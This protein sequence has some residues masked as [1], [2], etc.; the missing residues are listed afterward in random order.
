[1]KLR[2]QTAIE[3]ASQDTN[4]ANNL[5]RYSRQRVAPQCKVVKAR[6]GKG[7]SSNSSASRK[8]RQRF[9]QIGD[10][11]IDRYRP[12]SQSQEKCCSKTKL[13]SGGLPR[14]P[15]NGRSARHS[16]SKQGKSSP[17]SVGRHDPFQRLNDDVIF[18]VVSMLRPVDT[19]TLRRVSKLWKATSEFH[20]GQKLLHQH[21]PATIL[22]THNVCTR[23]EANLQYRRAR[24][25]E[26]LELHP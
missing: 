9:L 4:K 2:S 19:E 15:R 25:C 6:P 26:C 11:Q 22:S 7:R 20:C 17:P 8:K 16:R 21:L 10:G 23:E 24:K 12:W 5:V 14:R 1:M 13:V 18:T 3:R